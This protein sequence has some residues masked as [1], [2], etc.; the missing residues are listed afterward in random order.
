[1]TRKELIAKA[2][3]VSALLD[4]C[5]HIERETVLELTEKLDQHDRRMAMRS[6]TKSPKLPVSFD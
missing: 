6:R 4:G 5:N 1:M 3:A 2:E